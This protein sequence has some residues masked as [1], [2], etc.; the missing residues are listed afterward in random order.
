[1]RTNKCLRTYDWDGPDGMGIAEK[2]EPDS[3]KKQKLKDTS[4]LVLSRLRD[5]DS[6]VAYVD[7]EV[8]TCKGKYEHSYSIIYLEIDSSWC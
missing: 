3:E 4:Q 1:M 2:E 5:Y 7:V 8:L 6:G